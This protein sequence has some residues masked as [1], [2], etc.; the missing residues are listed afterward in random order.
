MTA[1]VIVEQKFFGLVELGANGM[2]LYS[3]IE[4]DDDARHFPVPGITGCNF[5]SEVLP[6][7]NVK[8]FQNCLDGFIRGPQQAIS[9]LFTCLYEDGPMQVKVLLSRMRER[10]EQDVTKSILVHIRRAQ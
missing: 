2:V 8:E 6:F 10:Y 1:S 5:Y 7:S 9:F 3:R 4:S